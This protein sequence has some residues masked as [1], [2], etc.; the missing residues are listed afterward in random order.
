MAIGQEVCQIEP[1]FTTLILKAKSMSAEER[2]LRSLAVI[3]CSGPDAVPFL[4]GQLTSDLER[5]DDRT[6]LAAYATPQGRVIAILRL[7]GRDDGLYAL[8]PAALASTVI[9]RL[10]KFVLRAKVRIDALEDWSVTWVGSDASRSAGTGQPADLASG[11]VFEYPDGRRLLA[12]PG[13]ATANPAAEQLWHAADVAAGLPQISGETTE[14][15]V[16]QML[17]LDLLDAISFTKGC[18]TGQEIV[19]RTQNLGRIKRRTFRFG[20][21]SDEAPAP[22]TALHLDATKVGEVLMCARVAGGIELLA[23]VA[24]DARDRPLRTASGHTALPL[25]LPYTV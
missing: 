14:H 21:R 13:A 9:G 11:L 4:Q 24:L 18:Y 23:V 1:S 15:Y 19:A 3:H 10:R 12:R 7:V 8:L 17:N 22:L 5:L 6:Q 25:R 16:P 20:V 2:C